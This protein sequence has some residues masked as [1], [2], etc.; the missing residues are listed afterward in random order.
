[1]TLTSCGAGLRRA[2]RFSKYANRW[3]AKSAKRV[4][5]GLLSLLAPRDFRVFEKYTTTYPPIGRPE[6]PHEIADHQAPRKGPDWQQ[7]SP[8]AMLSLPRNKGSNSSCY[9]R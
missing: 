5:K 4:A 2:C 6:L 8:Y 1:M 7:I 9:A 3:G